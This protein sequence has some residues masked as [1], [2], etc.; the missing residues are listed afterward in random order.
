MGPVTVGTAGHIDHGKS[1]LV[2]TLTGI[3]PDRLAEEQRRGMTLDLGFAHLDLPGGRRIGIIDVP[4]HEALIHNM[5]AGAGGIDLVMLV[6]AADEG[7]MPQTREHL[8]ILRFVRLTGGVVVLNKIDLVSDV[9]WLA[10]VE[11]DLASLVAGTVLEGSPIVRVSART[12]EG[13]P[14]LIATLD[15][16]VA[17]VPVRPAEGPARLPVD[18][19]F[20]MQGFGTVV[21]GTLW[22][23]TL[24]LGDLLTVFP[25]AR[26]VRVRGLQVHG[27]SVAEAYAGSRVAVNLAGIEKD[28]IERGDVLAA[29]GAFRPTDRVDVRLRLLPGA[30][31][32]EPSARVHFH[33]GSGATIGRVA[34]VD[35]AHLHPGEEG[36]V[37]L[38]LE[39]PV[40]AVHGDRFVLRRYS[41]T[42]TLGG[43]VILNASPQRRRGAQAAAV[44]EAADQAGPSALVVAAV[45]ARATG[46][47]PAADVA[48]V[49][50][51]EEPAAAR[52]IAAALATGQLIEY[53]DRLFAQSVI[54]GFRRLIEETLRGYHGR[55]PWRWGMP[56]ED[57]KSRVL[58]G[59]RDRLFDAVLAD[60]LA[61]SRIVNQRGLLAL[62]GFEPRLADGDQRVRD[63]LLKTLEAG[64]PS[65]P[66]LD[67][68]RRT[69]DTSIVDRMLQ[70]LMDDGL[71]V[72][73]VPEL[74]FAT[75]VVDR[76]KVMVID[77]LRGGSDV[78]VAILRD[79]LQTSRRYALALL[80]YFDAVRV[81][82]R[83]GDRRVL[84]PNADGPGR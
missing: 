41:P 30:P 70:A 57:L 42:E 72:A 63:A 51:V 52:A 16:L 14:E 37:Q 17:M 1:A 40:V 62:D 23:G 68:L 66:P 8:D 6:V 25:R 5:L 64:G 29:P 73:V 53:G 35:R 84:G 39:E 56:R 31:V 36:L 77:M 43:G 49:A 22:N 79:R 71:V 28:E 13:I 83:V 32:L 80:E 44:L 34:L 74:R 58:G 2:R 27:T 82:R 55:T 50:G 21:T 38:R 24:R 60:L 48:A 33:L 19:S 20:T 67:D 7:A 47:L 81:T 45:A 11:D 46:G 26:D 3:D 65:P 18:R 75:S 59:G 76:V 4:G 54:D 78:T 10:A 9:E 15:H 12:G 69:A 61:R